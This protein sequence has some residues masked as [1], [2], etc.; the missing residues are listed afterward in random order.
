MS[1]DSDAK[2]SRDVL[3]FRSIS[4]IEGPLNRT[5]SRSFIVKA[6]FHREGLGSN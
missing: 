6:I 5:S 1:L 4:G 2:T 3:S